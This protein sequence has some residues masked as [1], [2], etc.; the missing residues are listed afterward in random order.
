ML[1]RRVTFI[2]HLQVPVEEFQTAALAALLGPISH[3]YLGKKGMIRA[4]C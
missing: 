4:R 3:E 1:D 2:K